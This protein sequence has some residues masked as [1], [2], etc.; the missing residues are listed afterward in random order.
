M[1]SLRGRHFGGGE[2]RYGCKL[3]IVMVGGRSVGDTLIAER[4]A[5]PYGGGRR[6]W[7]G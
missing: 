7:C 5:R 2:D 3:R 6:S 4:L 1:F